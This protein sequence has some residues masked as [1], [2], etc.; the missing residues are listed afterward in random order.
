MTWPP[1]TE[2]MQYVCVMIILKYNHPETEIFIER[3]DELTARRTSG[4]GGFL[5][6]P[7]HTTWDPP[8]MQAHRVRTGRFVKHNET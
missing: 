4:K 7:P 6:L 3:L 2:E 8:G 5:A 1:G